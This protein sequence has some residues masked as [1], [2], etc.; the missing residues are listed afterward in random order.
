MKI[1][2]L[3]YI[4]TFFCALYKVNAVNRFHDFSWKKINMILSLEY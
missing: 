3:I 4:G 1:S 2:K